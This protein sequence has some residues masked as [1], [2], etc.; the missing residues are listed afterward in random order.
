ME[1]NETELSVFKKLLIDTFASFKSFCENHNLTFYG[2]DG[3]AIG[4][5]RHKGFIPWDDD[6]DVYMKREDY[7]KFISLKSEL[8]NS[9]YE[10]LD[11]SDKG[12]YCPF[13]KY[14]SKKSSIWEMEK[15]PIMFGAYIDVFPLELMKGTLDNV[16]KRK[17]NYKK[18]AD[19]YLLAT[20]VR[21]WSDVSLAICKWKLQSALWY[22]AEILVFPHFKNYIL[23]KMEIERTSNQ[24]TDESYLVEITGSFGE[25]QIFKKEWF[26]TIVMMTFENIEMPM[27][28]GYDQMLRK[29]YG[30]YMK[31]PPVEQQKTHHFHYYYNLERRVSIEEAKTMM[32]IPTNH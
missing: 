20:I 27:P 7:D 15:E 24:D 28:V 17:K 26:D 1:M 25:K 21:P 18:W 32:T 10:I 4:V 29:Q 8:K 3:T 13:A 19:R 22:M 12:Y 31:L 14:V 30:D 5:V 2:C 6:I 11:T 23:R 16:L 9:D